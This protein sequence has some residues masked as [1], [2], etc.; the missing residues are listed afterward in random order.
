MGA[1]TDHQY[2]RFWLKQKHSFANLFFLPAIISLRF[3]PRL[4]FS[5]V[6]LDAP[7]EQR[8]YGFHF[9]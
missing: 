9:G 4:L 8:C 5:W 1:S 6:P 7:I 2:D 3:Y